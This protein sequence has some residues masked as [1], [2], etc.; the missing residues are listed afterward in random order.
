[1]SKKYDSGDSLH[2]KIIEGVD[3]LADNV[4]STLGP[5]G[6]N[7]IIH[8]KGKRPF[9]TKDGVTVAKFIGFDDEFMN[10]GAQ[11]VKQAAAKT[12][13]DAGDGTTTSTVLARAIFKSAMRHVSAGASPIEIKRG[14]D[15]AVTVVVEALK[16]SSRPIRSEEDVAHIATISA[17]GDV[18][19]GN[20]IAL[21]V[22]RVGKD[23]SITIE[24]ARSIETGLDLME[25]F[26][27]DSGNVASAF[28][29]DERRGTINYE[30]PMFLI[31]SE[32]IEAV[33]QILPALEIAARE[34]RPFVIIA[35]DIA[36]QAL[37]AL[38]MNSMRGTMKVAA[39]K[40]PRYGEERRGIM[41]D[42][43]IATGGHYFQKS[44]GDDLKNVE[45]TH[46]GTAKSV[47]LGK[48]LTTIVSGNGNMDEVENR[49]EAL[50]TEIEVTDSLPDA[51]RLQERI[52]RLASGVAVI[53]VGAA[54][55]IEMIEK[56]H[57]IEDALEAV[58]SAQL[59]GVIPGGGLALLRIA[60]K[61]KVKTDTEEQAIG[62]SIVKEALD[63]P[64]RQMAINCG[65][66]E[67]ITLNSIL[68]AKDNIGI[69]FSTGELAD[70]YDIGVIDPVK[71]TRC[72]LINAVS[73]AGT[74]LTTNYAIIEVD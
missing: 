40:A 67:D 60:E 62:V 3:T 70:M 42:L 15:K 13:V 23:G 8:A 1:M 39:I 61:I 20:L 72:A 35:D 47:E 6:R 33:E 12:S 48:G 17:N 73:V 46:F 49:I 14:M 44:R 38:I 43:A 30:N 59:E 71:V 5:R 9:I 64:T 24:E 66:S 53:K 51:E 28:I 21:A 54:T 29:T 41:S 55:E 22:D 11:I 4:A 19:I 69:N 10:V 50:K 36:G 45:L 31:A 65:M 63:A 2:Q 74:L 26:R 32:K 18:E 34:N 68:M 52:T 16:E 37:A 57:R 7:V 27:M 25:G 56:K 58:R